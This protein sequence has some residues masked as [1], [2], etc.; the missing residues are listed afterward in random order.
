MR[1]KGQYKSQVRESG[2]I[3]EKEREKKREKEKKGRKREKEIEGEA[4]EE[5][6]VAVVAGGSRQGGDGGAMVGETIA[7]GVASEA[8]DQTVA[9]IFG[10]EDLRSGDVVM[11]EKRWR[12]CKGDTVEATGSLWRNFLCLK[13]GLCTNMWARDWFG[14]VQLEVLGAVDL[15]NLMQQ[16]WEN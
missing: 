1:S 13:L 4:R 16:I 7:N 11:L 2:R 6:E 5:A 9:E 12:W 8:V 15:Q 10:K 3:G 14:L